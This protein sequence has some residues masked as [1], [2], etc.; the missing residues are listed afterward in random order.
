MFENFDMHT[1]IRLTEPK[2]SSELSKGIG[3][4]YTCEHQAD[5]TTYGYLKASKLIMYLCAIKRSL[6][7]TIVLIKRLQDF[8]NVQF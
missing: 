3:N 8:T 7:R 2:G 4:F 6:N 5:T 1:H